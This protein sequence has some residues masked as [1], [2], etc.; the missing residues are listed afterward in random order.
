ME[1]FRF[2]NK[3]EN[4]YKFCVC[5]VWYFVIFIYLF[6]T[7]WIISASSHWIKLITW[8]KIGPWSSE[9]ICGSFWYP[10]SDFISWA[11]VQAK[12]LILVKEKQKLFLRKPVTD[13]W[14]TGWQFH[15]MKHKK[16][17]KMSRNDLRAFA[18]TKLI[19]WRV[20]K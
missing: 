15:A 20:I 16:I 4:E 9:D 5:E 7:H 12:L 13:K 17:H 18:L 1:S 10:L 8:Y 6:M 19:I 3:D 14:K 2:K 11:N